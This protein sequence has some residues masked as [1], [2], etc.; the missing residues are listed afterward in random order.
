MVVVVMMMVMM[1]MVMMVA[2]V[3]MRGGMPLRRHRLSG[4]RRHSEPDRQR[5]RG[6]YYLLHFVE[7]PFYPQK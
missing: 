3:M 1:M 7:F 4:D 2:A 5:G 6:D